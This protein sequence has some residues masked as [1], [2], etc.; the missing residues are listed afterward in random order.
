MTSLSL[1]R[2]G[3]GDISPL[4][5]LS[6]LALVHLENNRIRD[7]SPSVSLNS[8]TYLNLEGNDISDISPL[9]GNGG[10][11]IGVEIRLQGNNLDLRDGSRNLEGVWL[12][13]ERGVVVYRDP[14]V[15][16]ILD[17]VTFPDSSLEAAVRQ[18]LQRCP[19]QHVCGPSKPAGESISARE[20]A[21]ITG[22]SSSSHVRNLSGIEHLVNLKSLYL[23]GNEINDLSPLAGLTSLTQLILNQ[24]HIRDLSSL[25]NLTNLTSLQI[26][27]N[28]ITDLSPLANLNNLTELD[29]S[30]NQVANISPLANLTNLTQ[31]RIQGTPPYIGGVAQISDVSCRR[32]LVSPI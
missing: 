15:G 31:L 5:N 1:A 8:L 11:G 13:G 4:V 24:N 6:S 9:V 3:I 17:G 14:I 16:P 2:T 32:W 26:W 27:G 7:I 25:S 10:L 21:T 29:L 23:W 19:G 28:Q 30:E 18:A 22:V 20:L 12:L